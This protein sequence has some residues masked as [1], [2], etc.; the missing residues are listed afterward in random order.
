V[1]HEPIKQFLACLRSLDPQERWTLLNLFEKGLK[2]QITRK[3]DELLIG[4][5]AMEE[6]LRVVAGGGFIAS[7]SALKY[8]AVVLSMLE[9]EKDTAGVKALKSEWTQYVQQA[10]DAKSDRPSNQFIEIWKNTPGSITKK[11]EAVKAELGG[12]LDSHKKRARRYKK[13]GKL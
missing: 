7:T 3:S 9:A 11:A 12:S 10:R 13:G 1:S 6:V 2:A 8:I 4:I 5:R